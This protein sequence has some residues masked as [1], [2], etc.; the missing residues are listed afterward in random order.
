MVVDFCGICIPAGD[1][2][3]E[4]DCNGEIGGD[5]VVDECGVCGGDG[6]ADGTCD[7]EG[8][9]DLGCGCG[10]PGPSGCDETCGSTL[11]FDECGVCGGGGIAEGACDCDG[12]VDLGCGCGLDGIAEGAC[13]CDGNVDLGCGCGED[14]IAEGACDCDG[15]VDLGCGCGLNGIAEGACDCDGNV[16]F[17]GCGCGEDAAEANYDCDGNFTGA[18]VQVIHNSASPTVDVYIDSSLAIPDFEY[19]TATPVLELS[20]S[21]TVGIAAAGGEVIAE[22]PFD[23]MVGGSYVVVATGLLGGDTTP[24]DLAATTTTFGASSDDLVG[25]EVYHG[26]TDAPAVDVLADANDGSVLVADLAYGSFSGY[27]EV[28]AADYTLGVA[29]SGSDAIAA[30]TAPLSGLGGGS[31]VAFA[32][33]FLAPAGDD[34]PAFGVFAALADGTVLELPALVQD[35]AGTWGGDSVEDEC[36]LCDGEGIADGTCDCDGN[37]DLGCGCAELAPSLCPDGFTEVCDLADCPS[38]SDNEYYLVDL[39]NTGVSQLT[40]FESSISTLQ[41]GDEI[42]IFDFNAIT[43]YNDCSNVIGELLVGA[44]IWDGTQLSIV[45]TGSVDQCGFGG[46]QLPGYVEGNEV[47]VRVYRSSTGQ[48]FAANLTW[49]V[50]TGGSLVIYSNLCQT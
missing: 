19:R 9:V 16:D 20:T 2:S 6:I 17:F 26:S 35:C 32:S 39:N 31:A 12:N 36:G 49:S 24:F 42:G 3:C 40:I 22:F 45:S 33:G 15:N 8:N 30:F 44:G 47:N 4:A 48:E 11:E 14:G 7:C 5:A 37:I 50:G 23:L 10:E 18:Y 27:V 34:D 43:N 41:F 38:V 1:T 13:D 25:L 46:P 28:P 29:P 21:F